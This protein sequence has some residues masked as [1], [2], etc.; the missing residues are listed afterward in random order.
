MVTRLAPF[1]AT[2]EGST[3]LKMYLSLWYVSVI[4]S[5]KALDTSRV[6]FPESPASTPL[7]FIWLVNGR[8]CRFANCS[9]P[10]RQSI[11]SF[12]AFSSSFDRGPLLSS[13]TGDLT[14]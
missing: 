14:Y 7:P 4:K 5:M 12:H 13:V 8:L 6:D 11:I 2:S 3:L 1:R 10:P 9:E